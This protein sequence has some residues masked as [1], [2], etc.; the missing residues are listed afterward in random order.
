M[1]DKK[2][3][4]RSSASKRESSRHS[5]GRHG[6]DIRAREERKRKLEGETYRVEERSRDGYSKERFIQKRERQ[7][8]KESSTVW[9][10][11][12]QATMEYYRSR[13]PRQYNKQFDKPPLESSDRLKIRVS[14]NQSDSSGP[15]RDVGNRQQ[16]RLPGER[17]VE[18]QDSSDES[19][20]EIPVTEKK[21]KADIDSLIQDLESPSS[22]SGSDEK[23][24]DSQERDKESNSPVS[25]NYENESKQSPKVN[26]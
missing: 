11:S 1:S 26:E 25:S 3:K 20:G 10:R 19:D 15:K 23:E 13:S 18:V 4:K 14:V 24:E 12:E 17:I 21:H 16:K 2:E 8:T 22:S 7:L 5:D 6:K 9:R